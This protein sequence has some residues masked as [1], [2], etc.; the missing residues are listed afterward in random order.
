MKF[1]A[2]AR[3]ENHQQASGALDQ[4]HTIACRDFY[5]SQETAPDVV[6]GPVEMECLILGHQTSMRPQPS[7]V[8]WVLQ[9]IQSDRPSIS[10]SEGGN[11]K[12]KT[13]CEQDQGAQE[14]CM[15]V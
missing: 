11:G 6:L 8:S 9:V 2:K 12:S 3:W 4:G 15:N 10:P 5:D 7:T 13:G 1:F 14:S